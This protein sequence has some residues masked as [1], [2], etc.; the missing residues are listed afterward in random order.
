V[1]F[2]YLAL[3]IWKSVLTLAVTEITNCGNFFLRRKMTVF[4]RHR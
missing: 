2:H 1:Y 4:E 3:L